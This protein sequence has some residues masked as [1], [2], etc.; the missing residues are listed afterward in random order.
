MANNPIGQVTLVD[1]VGWHPLCQGH[2]GENVLL[3]LNRY[4]N[5]SPAVNHLFNSV[6]PVTAH[7]VFKGPESGAYCDHEK[8]KILVE[9]NLGPR[10]I[11]D[12][13][14]FELL[15]WHAGNFSLPVRKKV[16]AGTISLQAAGREIATSESKVTFNHAKLMADLKGRQVRISEFG[17]KS[18]NGVGVADEKEFVSIML[19]SPHNPNAPASSPS[20][21]KSPELYMWDLLGSDTFPQLLRGATGG[22]T[23]E[24][25]DK[26]STL[27]VES[28]ESQP[29]AINKSYW[30]VLYCNLLALYKKLCNQ[31]IT[32]GYDVSHQMAALAK[33]KPLSRAGSFQSMMKTKIEAWQQEPKTSLKPYPDKVDLAQGLLDVGLLSSLPQ[34]TIRLSGKVEYED[35]RIASSK[36]ITLN[37]NTTVWSGFDGSF[38][39]STKETGPHIIT[40]YYGKNQKEEVATK[41]ESVKDIK[42]TLRV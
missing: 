3:K 14:I 20:K 27:T 9:A 40:V 39:F 4:Y 15:N 8:K 10:E 12:S 5:K 41:G 24:W 32:V 26:C 1:E 30:I 2:I 36:K 42:I 33:L 16:S 19:K 35:G 23:P 22:K 6:K 18:I 13:I 25:F 21:L 31:N 29:E 37:Q 11:A 38:S 28:L 17:E 34:K 7:I